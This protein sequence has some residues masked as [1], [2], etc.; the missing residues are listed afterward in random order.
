[1]S[2][3]YAAV[4][5][6]NGRAVA[7]PPL[8]PISSRGFFSARFARECHDRLRHVEYANRFALRLFDARLPRRQGCTNNLLVSRRTLEEQLLAGLQAKV[9]HPDVV[10]YTFKRLE[11][12]LEQLLTEQTG[13]AATVRRR[14]EL[15][16]RGIR[17]CTEAIASMGLSPSLRTQLTDLETEHRELS[18]KLI[19]SEP[20]AVRFRVVIAFDQMRPTSFAL[21]GFESPLHQFAR[22]TLV[23]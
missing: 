12:E 23:L 14:L 16:E 8:R 5:P 9:L 15:V 1:L 10:E 4:G 6:A 19:S 7:V 11:E 2:N 13:E 3:N 17:N 21:R 18:E 20:S 22:V